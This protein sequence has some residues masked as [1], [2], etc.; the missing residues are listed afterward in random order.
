MDKNRTTFVSSRHLYYFVGALCLFLLT[1]CA[2][3]S[4]FTGRFV[5]DDIYGIVLNPV[6]VESRSIGD[7][8]QHFPSRWLAY[9][10][11]RLNYMLSGFNTVSYHSVNFLLHVV[12]SLLVWSFVSQLFSI[13]F[14]DGLVA[15]KKRFIF[16][17]M[18]ACVFAVHPV[19]TQAVSYI[20]QRLTL[21]A[22]FFYLSALCFYLRAR[23]RKEKK[24]FIVSACACVGGMFSKET[25]Y[26]LP[27]IVFVIEAFFF[28]NKLVWSY[29]KKWWKIALLVAIVLAF[30]FLYLFEPYSAFKRFSLSNA[31]SHTPWQYFLTQFRVLLLYIRLVWFPIHLNADYHIPVSTTLLDMRV[32]LGVVAYVA[33]VFSAVYSFK[34]KQRVVAFAILW[35]LI[36][37][38]IESSLIPLREIAAEHRLYLP[39]VG[40]AILFNLLL[41]RVFKNP[42]IR[43]AVFCVCIATFVGLSYQRN[44][45]WQEP[46]A[47]WEDVMKKSP[48]KARAYVNYGMLLSQRGEHAHAFEKYKAALAR[49]PDNAA[50]HFNI[51]KTYSILGNAQAA[52]DHYERALATAREPT[53]IKMIYYN[54]GLLHEQTD[55]MQEALAAFTDA[56][57]RDEH[58]KD[59]YFQ[60]GFILL[61]TGQHESAFRDFEIARKLGYEQTEADRK[62]MGMYFPDKIEAT[63]DKRLRKP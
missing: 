9:A 29:A 15:G 14:D 23:I 40:F 30:F 25:I 48:A 42:R 1:F 39:L 60:R 6:V 50:A 52:L 21:L 3:N 16:A 47:F 41:M 38:I 19:Q 49:E 63:K 18:C 26:T 28:D 55:Q 58:F 61:R 37:P 36:T 32:I 35:F 51:A 8:F 7:I 46:F 20:V 57:H 34:R 62:R 17:F 45:V 12:N 43:I 11:F 56:I 59:A 27:L 10:S 44:I 53:V 13:R 4:S 24:Y 22:A 2:Y 31:P 5:F 33:L 54:Q